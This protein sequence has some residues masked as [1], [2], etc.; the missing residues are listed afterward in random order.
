MNVADVF[1]EFDTTLRVSQGTRS[2]IAGRHDRIARILNADFRHITNCTD[3]T[4][5]VGSYG[6][7]TAIEGISD[8][9]MLIILPYSIQQQ[10][11]RYIYNGQSA[12]LQAVRSSLLGTYP[13]TV[14]KGDGQI[15]QVTF[16]DGTTFEIL[17][18]FDNYNGS[19]DF[20]DSN[21]GGSWKQTYP[22]AEINAFQDMNVQCNYNLYPLCRMARAWKY[23][24]GVTLKSCLLD[25][26]AY[27]F[28]SD[29]EYRNKSYLYHD[30]MMRDYFL[31]LTD[32][33][34]AQSSWVMVGSGRYYYDNCYFQYKAKMAYN[35][36]LE[37]INYQENN[38]DWS[39]HNK[40]RE[41]FGNKFPL[42]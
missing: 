8:I 7:G 31:Y 10:Y 28:L 23:N 41:I 3:N 21:N 13:N 1:K 40:W 39:A 14:I 27:R 32:I 12:L 38:H 33:P 9:D 30:Y 5:Y 6:R 36:S 37:A 34:L 24:N 25:L 11:D 22:K 26:F 2:L 20:P 15:V 17:P 42:S 35:K 29:W 19:Y 18:C 16:S 4:L